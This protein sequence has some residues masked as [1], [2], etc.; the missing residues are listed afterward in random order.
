M[1]EFG[2]CMFFKTT[3]ISQK[4]SGYENITVPTSL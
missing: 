1:Y 4:L 3:N 2:L